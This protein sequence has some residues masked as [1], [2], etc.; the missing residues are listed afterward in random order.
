MKSVFPSIQKVLQGIHLGLGLPQ[1]PSAIKERFVNTNMTQEGMSEYMMVLLNEIFKELDADEESQKAYIE[2]LLRFSSGYTELFSKVWVYNSTQKNVVWHLLGYFFAPSIARHMAFWNLNIFADLDKGMPRERFWY[3]PE[4]VY[5]RKKG[6]VYLPVEQVIDWICDLI[7]GTVSDIAKAYD[8]S[9]SEEKKTEDINNVS[10]KLNQWRNGVLPNSK[11]IKE[12]F[13]DD[14]EL[15]FKGAFLIDKNM[16]LNEKFYKTRTFLLSKNISSE[17]ISLQIGMHIPDAN[18]SIEIKEDFVSYVVERYQ[19]PSN[20]TIRTRLLYARMIQNAYIS[21]LNYLFPEVD[22]RNVNLESNK[23]L[24]VFEIYKRIYNLTMS[25]WNACGEVSDRNTERE[26]NLYFEQELLNGTFGCFGI[27][28]K[29]LYEIILPSNMHGNESLSKCANVLTYMINKNNELDSLSSLII[30]SPYDMKY[31]LE[32]IDHAIRI[33]CE[34]DKFSTSLKRGEGFNIALTNI[35]EFDLACKLY[36]DSHR[37]DFKMAALDRMSKMN[38]NKLQDVFFYIS[39]LDYLLRFRKNSMKGI[40]R[41]Y[42]VDEILSKIKFCDEYVRFIPIFQWFEAKHQLNMGYFDESIE[43]Y[44]KA[45]EGFDNIHCG[46]IKGEIIR[47]LFSIELH[48]HPT[49]INQNNYERDYR[50]CLDYGLFTKYDNIKDFN[51]FVDHCKKYFADNLYRP[52]HKM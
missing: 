5:P 33:E 42:R 8:N 35:N 16:S 24:Q 52:Y 28:A 34:Y 15:D 9:C 2:N 13:N 7:S 49:K 26:E 43:L 6:E 4:F 21:L 25:A 38:R 3:L 47:E 36:F 18:D 50:D 20:K 40:D 45:K 51:D 44:K 29:T 14:I 17:E 37:D 31:K 12:I 48:L 1:A 22:K 32:Y 11:D 27:D 41:K 39:Y 23:L 30:L 19:I 10:R 46:K